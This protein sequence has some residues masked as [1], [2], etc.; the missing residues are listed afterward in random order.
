M[1]LHREL[2]SIKKDHPDDVQII[3]ASVGLPRDQVISYMKKNSFPFHFVSG[4]EQF[5]AF[6]VPGLP[7]Q[8]VYNPDGKLQSVF[9]GFPDKSQLD[10]LRTLIS[11]GNYE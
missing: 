5:S 7:A 10:S 3:A 2:A 6:G 8:L 9:L 1:N 11:H 4:S